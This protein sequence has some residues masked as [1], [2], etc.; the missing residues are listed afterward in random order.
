MDVIINAECSKPPEQ[1]ETRDSQGRALLN[2][3]VA[4]GHDVIQLPVAEVLRKHKGLEGQWVVLSPVFWKATHNDALILAAGKELGIEK[5][6][7][8]SY[9]ESYSSF[10]AESGMTLQYYDEDHWLLSVKDKPSLHAK[11]V[12]QLI[13]QSLMPELSTLDQSLYWQKF[14]TET[15]MYFATQSFYSVLNGVWLWGDELNLKDSK[16]AICADAQWHSLAE[17]MSPNVT[18][19]NPEVRLKEFQ[20][21]LINDFDSLSDAH[22]IELDNQTVNWFWNN[23]AYTTKSCSVLSRLW[24]KLIHAH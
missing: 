21:V 7:L 3:L 4:L 9:F 17:V 10:L 16:K 12:Y 18:L 19:Y 5:K 1:C 2:C 23:L 13:N 22:K 11:P 15:Q 24:R 20:I 8:Q 14:L 6:A